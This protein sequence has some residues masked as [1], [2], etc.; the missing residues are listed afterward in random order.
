MRSMRLSGSRIQ[1]SSSIS[2]STSSSGRVM[3]THIRH[4]NW[5]AML[6]MRRPS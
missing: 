6:P 1:G 2:C 5:R 3:T 4:G